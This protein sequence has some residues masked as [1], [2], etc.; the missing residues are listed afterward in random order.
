MQLCRIVP[1]SYHVYIL[2][3]RSIPLSWK[4]I[5]A[6]QIDLVGEFISSSHNINI[7]KLE[8]WLPVANCPVG[9]GNTIR[10]TL[11]LCTQTLSPQQAGL[12]SN[13]GLL[14]YTIACIYS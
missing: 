13:E 14:L 6:L 5:Q 8:K 9:L 11:G 10:G 12:I 7:N 1:N 2:H 3:F 4:E